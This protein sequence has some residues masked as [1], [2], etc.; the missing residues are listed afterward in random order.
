M[1][2]PSSGPIHVSSV[3]GHL[4][5]RYA[6]LAS[7]R[8]VYIG[9]DV[10]TEG[11]ATWDEAV[12]VT[13]PPDEFRRY[14]REYIRAINDGSLRLHAEDAQRNP[15]QASDGSDVSDTSDGK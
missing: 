9:A 5:T 13:I 12:I 15:T 14:R 4:V 2:P 10:D 7:A 3:A 6:S 11:N 8:L 1:K